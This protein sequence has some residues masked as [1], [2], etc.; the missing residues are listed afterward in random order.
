MDNLSFT[1]ESNTLSR[2]LKECLSELKKMANFFNTFISTHQ[3]EV[4]TF[5]KK[6]NL[7]KN[8]VSIHPSI[9]LSNLS[10]IYSFYTDFISNIKDLMTK[11]NNELINPLTEFS[12]EQ[13]NIY[14]ENLLKLKNIYIKYTEH[15][16]L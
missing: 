13:T 11:I 15:K 16:D 6:L 8:Q 7:S 9:L 5:Q 3:E 14:N 10:G 4:E 12:N 1:L 2:N